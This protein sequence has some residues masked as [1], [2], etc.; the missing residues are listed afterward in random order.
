MALTLRLLGGLTTDEIARAYPRPRADHRAA[1]RP[2]QEDAGEERAC[3]SRCRRRPSGWCGWPRVLEVIYLVFN[4]GYAATAGEDWI[5]PSLCEE[6]LRLGRVL[7][8]LVPAEAEAHGLV[9]LMELHASRL[10]A[11][12]GPRGEAILLL[13]QDR[14]ALGSAADRTRPGRAGARHRAR[15]RRRLLRAAGRHRRLSR[16]RDRAGGDRLGAH[17]RALRPLVDITPIAD[18]AA[19]PRRRR[20]PGRRAGG[21]PRPGRRARRQRSRWP[22]I[23]MLPSARGDLLE[24]LGRIDEARAEFERAAVHD[25]QRPRPRCPTRPGASP[26]ECGPS[27]RWVAREKGKR[28]PPCGTSVPL[29]PRPS[30]P[31]SCWPCRRSARHRLR[32]RPCRRGPRCRRA[33]TATSRATSSSRRSSAGNSRPASRSPASS[34]PISTTKWRCS[35]RCGSRRPSRSTSPR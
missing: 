17:R 4:E 18:R 32:Q 11:R 10:R 2:R 30:P 33:S 8:T 16:A 5:R 26:V 6:A 13:D 3:R 21:W 24:Q 29:P 22:A 1:H 23:P 28:G 20:G 31:R 25:A 15:R 35:A 12:L 14:G 7:A 19:Q 9:A 27:R 34:T